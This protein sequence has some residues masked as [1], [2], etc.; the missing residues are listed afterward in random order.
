M[1]AARAVFFGKEDTSVKRL[2]A[3]HGKKVGTYRA[4]ANRLRFAGAGD[5]IPRTTVERHLLEDVVLFLPIEEVCCRNGEAR[6]SRET[7]L[8]RN[9]PDLHQAIGIPKWQRF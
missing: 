2:N 5:V 8:W 3:K 7:G 1:V 9:V 6:H 4:G